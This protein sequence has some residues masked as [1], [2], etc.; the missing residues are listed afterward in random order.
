MLDVMCVLCKMIR[1]VKMMVIDVVGGVEM[2]GVKIKLVQKIKSNL[3]GA[4]GESCVLKL[5]KSF[6]KYLI[7]IKIMYNNFNNT[8][9]Y[10]HFHI[11]NTSIHFH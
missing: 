10:K 3:L 5:C 6:I 1:S 4:F 9:I 8:L 2:N 11:L 7:L